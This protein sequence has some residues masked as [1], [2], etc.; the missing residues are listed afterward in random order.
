MEELVLKSIF[1]FNYV[2]GQY[3]F[4]SKISNKVNDDSSLCLF[5][6]K[7][8]RE[9][10]KN[11]LGKALMN[12]AYNLRHLFQQSQMHQYCQH[13]DIQ[14]HFY[15]ASRQLLMSERVLYHSQCYLIYTLLCTHLW[16]HFSN[17]PDV[18]S[19]IYFRS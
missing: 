19:K 10:L 3:Q 16:L 14:R 7:L 13:G 17:K 15:F 4:S 6:R 2:N 11:L 5:I 1:V 9:L 18:E 8:M 12:L